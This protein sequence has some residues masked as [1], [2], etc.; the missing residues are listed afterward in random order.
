MATL[1]TE[2]I[3]YAFFCCDGV[4]NMGTEEASECADLVAAAHSIPYHMVPSDNA[5]GFDRS[6]AERFTAKGRLILAP[7]ESLKLTKD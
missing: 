3:D 6:V 7:G 2:G 1:S 5:A 4:Y